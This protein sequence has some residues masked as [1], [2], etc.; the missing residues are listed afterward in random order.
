MYKINP[1]DY[2]HSDIL[3]GKFKRLSTIYSHFMTYK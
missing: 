2:L 1:T 3:L